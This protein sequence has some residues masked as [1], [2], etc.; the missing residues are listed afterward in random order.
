M[1]NP[2]VREKSVSIHLSLSISLFRSPFLSLNPSI[3]PDGVIRQS[4]Q[5]NIVY[6]LIKLWRGW[7]LKRSRERIRWGEVSAVGSGGVEESWT[8]LEMGV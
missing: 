6:P 8:G 7:R 4:Q 1:P 3:R 2:R 5:H